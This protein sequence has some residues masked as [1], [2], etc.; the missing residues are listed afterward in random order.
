MVKRL[1]GA[2]SSSLRTKQ[3]AGLGC[4]GAGHAG[5]RGAIDVRASRVWERASGGLRPIGSGAVRASAGRSVI[6][7]AELDPGL[8]GS[9]V[10]TLRAAG[11]EVLEAADVGQVL[12]LWALHG[13]EIDAAVI[14]TGFSASSGKQLAQALHADRPELPMLALCSPGEEPIPTDR[15]PLTAFLRKPFT[16]HALRE[17]IAGMLPKRDA[18]G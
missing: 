7:V 1:A 16:E 17:R 18:G 3:E 2:S 13:E 5:H 8:R 10:A 12:D 4:R 6:L 14:D 9:A 15:E 11:F